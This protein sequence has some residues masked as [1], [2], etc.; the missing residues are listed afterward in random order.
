ML[1]R[2]KGTD[3]GR[4]QIGWLDS[5][6]TFSF[7]DYY[8]PAHHNYRTLRVINDDIIAPG[9]GFGTHPHRDMEILTCMLSGRLAHKDSLGTGAELRP[10]EWQVMTAG[11]GIAHSEF[12]PS[13]TETAHLLQIWLVP[14]RKGHT[15]RYDQKAF[16][17]TPGEWVTVASPDARDGS[18]PIHQDA[19]VSTVTLAAGQSV[20]RPLEVDRGYWLHVATGEVMVNS[21]SLIA[22]DAVAIENETVL[23]VAGTG[24][25]LLFDVK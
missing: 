5:W 18:F 19:V 12:N 3:R 7:G 20:T 11:T 6:H 8:D 2:R 9:G 24:Q 17:T 25:V 4:T 10:G 15:P 1:T 23:T 13:D 14:D 16:D 21:T 22:G